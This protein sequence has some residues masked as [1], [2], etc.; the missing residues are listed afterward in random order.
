MSVA[1][2]IATIGLNLGA[3]FVTGSVGLLAQGLEAIVNLVA[4]IV[5]VVTLRIS[6]A[7]PDEEHE[8]GHDKA[9]YFSSALEGALILAAAASI[10]ITSVPRL[11]DP[12]PLE[13]AYLGVGLSVLAAAVNLAL[14][15]VLVSAGKRYRSIAL[16]ADGHHLMSDVYTTAGVLVGVGLVSAT[17]YSR[18]DPI[19]AICVAV[20]ILRTGYQLMHRSAMGLLDT[21]VSP[22]ERE[23]ITGIL[24]SFKDEGVV[25]HALRTRQAGPRRF[26]T[27][28]ILVPG[29]W[30][31]HRGHDVLERIE[32]RIAS[33]LPGT[34]TLTHLEPIEDARAWIDQELP[35]RTTG[36]AEGEPG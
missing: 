17:G 8:F 28:H 22:A 12:H 4:A 32:T 1:A 36:M 13:S 6:A 27:V 31:V 21:S 26:V 3:Y 34:V 10:V 14:S 2:A 5:A 30:T 7:P 11:F 18:L 25:W 24:D 19:V 20:L 33:A 35:P 29:E 9:E 15:R 16:E 23:E